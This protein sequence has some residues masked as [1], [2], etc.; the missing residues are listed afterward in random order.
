MDFD[1]C[2][3]FFNFIYYLGQRL[4]QN[5]ENTWLTCL[6][7]IVYGLHDKNIYTKSIAVSATYNK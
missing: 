2:H 1:V 7:D 6:I 3:Y 5:Q 4:L